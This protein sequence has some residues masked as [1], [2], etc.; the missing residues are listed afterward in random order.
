M[1][2]HRDGARINY[3]AIIEAAGGH[4]ISMQGNTVYFFDERGTRL[5]SLYVWACKR[6]NI[7][8]ALKS[9]REP[10]PADFPPLIPTEK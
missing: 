4:F 3:K 6:E 5:L 1:S 7:L 8:L 9:A 2:V 10:E